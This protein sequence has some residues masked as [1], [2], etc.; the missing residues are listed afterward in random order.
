MRYILAHMRDALQANSESVDAG[1]VPCMDSDDL[2]LVQ[3]AAEA[4]TAQK[5]GKFNVGGWNEHTWP[6]D[7]RN[8]VLYYEL[9]S[10]LYCG[11][12]IVELP[13]NEFRLD[14]ERGWV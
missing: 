13:E 8:W 7:V 11:W 14:Y 2:A 6:A 5:Q 9:P 10:G 12:R 3:A 4:V 1:W